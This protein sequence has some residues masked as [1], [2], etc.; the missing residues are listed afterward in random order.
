[1]V[2]RKMASDEE[3]RAKVAGRP[4]RS[5][6]NRLTDEELLARLR[7]FGIDLDRSSLERLCNEALSAE[8]IAMPLISKLAI[9][10]REEALEGDWIWVCLDALWQRWFPDEPSFEMLDDKM[11]TGYELNESAN[12]EA[13]CRIWLE[14]W[15]DV[16]HLFDKSGC[17]SIAEFDERFLGTQSLFNWIQELKIELWNAGL[18]DRQFLTARIAVCEAGLKLF[19]PEDE[20]LMGN[21]RR[22]LADSYFELGETGKADGL[23]REWLNTDPQ[24]GWGWIGWSD[25]HRFTC[26]ESVNLH[27]AEELLQEGLSIAGVRDSQDIAE[28]L[29]DLYEDQ[30]RVD[31]A[32]EIRQQAEKNSPEIQQTIEIFPGAKVVRQKTISTFGDEGL[33]LSEL[34]KLAN[35]FRASSAPVTGRR[36]KIGRNDPCP[37]GS[38]Q[39]FKKCCA[40]N[41]P[42]T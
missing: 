16:L 34:P 31:E 25:C 7:S 26:R 38:G 22:A 28:R 10:N 32:K 24:W 14:A 40:R 2:E 36:Q 12:V 3:F 33:P 21:C 9:K 4:L 20:L 8:E 17:Q 27:K 42:T 29:A 30:G 39:K 23:Y 19:D 37:C 11:Q 35:L 1:M 18:N 5:H 15:D 41:L 6:A 13:A